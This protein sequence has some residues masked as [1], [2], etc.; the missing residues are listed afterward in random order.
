M[1]MKQQRMTT[2]RRRTTTST[3]AHK[4]YSSSPTDVRSR[5]TR[6][7]DKVGSKKIQSP[8]EDQTRDLSLTKQ[9]HYHYATEAKLMSYLFLQLTSYVSVRC[10]DI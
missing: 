8:S 7:E 1:S 4:H 5:P 2:T 3:R 10:N 9:T 6:E